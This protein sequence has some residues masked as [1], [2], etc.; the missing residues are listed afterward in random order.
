MKINRWILAAILLSWGYSMSL[1]AEGP[2]RIKIF[3]TASGQIEEVE[4][5]VKTE[6]AWRT[7][8]TPEQFRIMRQKGTEKPGA[9][10]CTLPSKGE[11]GVYQCV[12]CGT[13][14]F[15]VDTKFES[16][17]GWP[18]FWESVSDLNIA[19]HTDDSYG[20]KRTEVLCA[21]CGAHLG[22]VFDDGPP[23]TGK[24][25]CING[26]ALKFVQL[27]PDAPGHLATAIFAAGC[28][29][30]VESE[31]AAVKGVAKTTV[32]YT[33]GSAKDPT[34]EQVCT[35]KT[36]HAEAVEVM[37]DPAVVSYAELLDVFW[38]IH[39]PTTPN[40]QGPDVGSQY[41]SAIFTLSPDQE[42][43][44]RSS[45]EM[46]TASGKFK[47]PIATEIVSAEPFYRAEE[48]HQKYFEKKGVKPTCH[49][50]AN[51]LKSSR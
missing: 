41:R 48:Y 51:L 42:R 47:A 19:L 15:R 40:R 5:V 35:D 25:Y 7:I 12:G 49:L 4:P 26:V 17:T 30:G 8:L 36:G 20:M 27:T 29:W 11:A 46:L 44:A 1:F 18:S 2:R 6:A 45:K 10:G 39:D 37:Y 9:S 50:P 3:N 34:Y 38:S 14:L 22:H 33:G 32:G 31:F 21:R 43:I 13:D 24:R 28:F 23:P 16:G